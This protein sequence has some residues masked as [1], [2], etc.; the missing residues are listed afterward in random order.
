VRRGKQRYPV[1]AQAVHG[2]TPVE[3][4]KWAPTLHGTP[5]RPI[6]GAEPDAIKVASPV[7][8]GEREETGEGPRLALTQLP[9]CRC[10]RQVSFGVR[11][12]KGEERDKLFWIIPGKLA[13]RPGPDRAPWN[14]AALRPGGRGAVLSV[15]DGLLCHPEDFV[16]AGLTSAGVPVSDNAPP[17]PG[18]DHLCRRAL[19]Q[20]YAFVQAQMALGPGV[21]V[22]CSSGK[23]RT[24][25]FR[26]YCLTQ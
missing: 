11:H 22:H 26:C 2:W 8:N 18:D 16:A 12:L 17:R 14:L 24:G 4:A 21:V 19:P 1:N 7:L 10:Q 25:L 5:W 20:A 13:G 3:L 15:N 6:T 9:R 23:D